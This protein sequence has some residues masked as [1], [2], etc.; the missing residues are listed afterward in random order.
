MI[1]LLGVE[2]LLHQHGVVLLLRRHHAELPREAE[3]VLCGFFFGVVS[4][5]SIRLKEGVW[6][7][8]KIERSQGTTNKQTSQRPAKSNNT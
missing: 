8:A 3:G 7:S 1:C 5:G 4:Q 2:G 6:K